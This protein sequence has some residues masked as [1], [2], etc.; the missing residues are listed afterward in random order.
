L[1]EGKALISPRSSRRS[2]RG[3]ISEQELLQGSREGEKRA[4]DKLDKLLKSD[5][6]LASRLEDVQGMIMDL[7]HVAGSRR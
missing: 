7:R 6:K 5:A 4:S 2:A 1:A 3:G